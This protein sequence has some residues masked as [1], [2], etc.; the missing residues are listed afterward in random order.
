MSTASTSA[1]QRGRPFAGPKTVLPFR[2]G[3]P[4]GKSDEGIRVLVVDD[5]AVVCKGVRSVLA[6]E[7]GM[8]VVDCVTRSSDVLPA[9]ERH[10]P[11]LVLMDISLVDAS[12]IDLTR[13]ILD[14]WPE[15]KVIAHSMYCDQQNVD[16]MLMA[17]ARGFVVKGNDTADIGLAIHAVRDGNTYLSKQALNLLADSYMCMLSAGRRMEAKEATRTEREIARLMVEGLDVKQIAGRLKLC[18]KTVYR[19]KKRLRHKLKLANDAA[20]IQHAAASGWTARGEQRP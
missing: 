20:L 8:Q 17:G 3:I 6:D 12:G 19:L 5:Q 2:G 11:D 1:F 14:K 7:P 15:V 10:R 18:D 16:G 4:D 9:V 13:M